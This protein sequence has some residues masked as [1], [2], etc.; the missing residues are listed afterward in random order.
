MIIIT[1]RCL[2]GGQTSFRTA[3]GPATRRR[4]NRRKR[5]SRPA[6][7]R[8][9]GDSGVSAGLARCRFLLGLLRETFRPLGTW[10]CPSDGAAH[11]TIR[12]RR[13]IFVGRMFQ[14]PRPNHI[15]RTPRLSP[16]GYGR[17]VGVISAP[18]P[19]LFKVTHRTTVDL[20]PGRF[21]RPFARLRA[22]NQ[23]PRPRVGCN[24]MS[25][26]R[27][28]LLDRFQSAPLCLKALPL[29]LTVRS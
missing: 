16:R 2:L 18:T 20:S 14:A 9:D 8:V 13:S 12:W 3:N 10:V 25:R 15:D 22:K 23:L 27:L 29:G 1:R 21:R 7:W 5:S 11:S 28:G 4:L 6:P 26:E 19:F 17:K 24:E